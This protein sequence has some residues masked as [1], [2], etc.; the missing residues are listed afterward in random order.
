MCDITKVGTPPAPEVGEMNHFSVVLD[1]ED[2]LKVANDK[3]KANGPVKVR[4]ERKDSRSGDGWSQVYRGMAKTQKFTDLEPKSTYQYRIQFEQKEKMTA[5]GPPVTVTTTREPLYA[6]NLHMAIK[7]MNLEELEMV[8]KSGEVSPDVQ[9]EDNFTALMAAAKKPFVEALE[10]L[11][12]YGADVNY[13]N[14]SGK[15]ALMVACITN[16]LESVKILRKYGADYTICDKGGCTAIHWAVDARNVKL[17]DFL[18]SDKADFNIKDSGHGGW[19]PLIRCANLHGDRDV[20]LALMMNGADIERTDN[21]GSTALHHSVMRK[22][23]ELTQVLLQRRSDPLVANKESTTPWQIATS[24]DDKKRIAVLMEPYVEK[25]KQERK[26]QAI[27]Q[28]TSK[29]PS[30]T[31]NNNNTGSSRTS[32]SSV[33]VAKPAV[34]AGT[35]IS[36]V[37]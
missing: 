30:V 28:A 31:T 26:R 23:L 8:L 35:V 10:M 27:S 4:V 25:I 19:T 14:P 1:W 22:H 12:E 7:K 9:N 15:T 5:F 20:G 6:E 17:I 24:H 29:G 36:P 3:C 18:G 21:N 13:T 16:Q 2:S 37:Q 34:K 32:S 33:A 11:L